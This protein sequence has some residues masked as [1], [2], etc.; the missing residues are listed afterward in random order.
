MYSEM[1]KVFRK[2]AKNGTDFARVGCVDDDCTDS[3]SIKNASKRKEQ[4]K[5]ICE[6]KEYNYEFMDTPMN[7]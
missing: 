7:F 4:G 2:Y 1:W 3:T 6:I 5:E